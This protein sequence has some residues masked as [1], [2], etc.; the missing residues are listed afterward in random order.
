L[1]FI[2][3][4]ERVYSAVQTEILYSTDTISLWR[5]P[6]KLIPSLTVKL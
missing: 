2:T 1:V 3:E 5:V 4:V 6:L